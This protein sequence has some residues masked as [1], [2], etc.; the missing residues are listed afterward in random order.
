MRWQMPPVVPYPP[1]NLDCGVGPIVL[2]ADNTVACVLTVPG[3]DVQYDAVLTVND[4]DT[5]NI[6]IEVAAEPLN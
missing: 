3:S 5:P 1:E 4:I 6:D 2:A